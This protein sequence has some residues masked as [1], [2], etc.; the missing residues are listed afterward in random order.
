MHV[1]VCP[2][3][4]AVCLVVGGIT[5]SPCLAQA[6]KAKG[7]DPQT[8]FE[9]MFDDWK[10]LLAELRKNT[11]EYRAA[12][13]DARPAIMKEREEI[14]ERGMA[15]QPKI[16]KAAESAFVAAP[17]KNK[18]VS[19]FLESMIQGAEQKEQYEEALRVANLLIA[20]N[21]ENKGVYSLA[22]RAAFNS[23]NFDEAAKDFK[24]A[25][26]ADVLEDNPGK[27][28]LAQ[29]PEYQK[30]WAKESELRAAEEKADDLPR[31]K[32]K[33]SKG[34][35]VVEL[36]ENEAPNTVANFISLVEKGTYDGTPFHRVLKGFM[37]QG[38]DPKGDG[39][40][41]PGYTIACECDKENH[42]D[43]FRGSLSMAHAGKDTGGS[44]FFLTFVPTPHLDGRHTV[45]GRIIE[46][47]DVLSELQRRD[48]AD[49]KDPDKIIEATV[50][51]KRDHKYQPVTVA[52]KK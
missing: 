5:S 29:V 13:E 38:G 44:Q 32:L 18:D 25:K 15:M 34:D 42:R 50:V 37:A 47:L 52:D 21:Y 24:L 36:F 35:I 9:S 16:M 41:G 11:L 8:V 22:G 45:F 39:T 19:V 2:I 12:K 46:G 1:R 23:N 14:L 48:P 49:P 31:V 7:Q 20:N 3:L 33:T 6:T 43:H 4:L 51:R 30:K 28:L 10:K 40:G 17:N 27:Q 26:E